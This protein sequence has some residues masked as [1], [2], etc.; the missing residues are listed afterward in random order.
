[1]KVK[2]VEDEFYPFYI[3]S[4]DRQGQ[5]IKVPERTLNRWKRILNE[6]ELLQEEIKNECE[7]QR[8]LGLKGYTLI[9]S[10]GSIDSYE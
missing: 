4:N 8:D 6:F 2:I 7:K 10:I 1:M 5:E 9:G 3:I